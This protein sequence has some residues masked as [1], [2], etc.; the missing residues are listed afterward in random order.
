MADLEKVSL[1]LSIN[2][3]IRKDKPFPSNIMPYGK[4]TLT[5]QLGPPEFQL[6]LTQFAQQKCHIGRSGHS[7][8]RSP[9]HDDGRIRG[10]VLQRI[11]W[12]FWNAVHFPVC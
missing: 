6:K 4:Y 9:K 11:F 2:N 3:N 7:V 10:Y 5:K 8:S 12:W 1:F